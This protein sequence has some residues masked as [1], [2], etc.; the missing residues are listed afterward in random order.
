[1][2]PP[3][4]RRASRSLPQLVIVSGPGLRVWVADSGRGETG[5]YFVHLWHCL[6]C[7][8]A[9]CPPTDHLPPLSRPLSPSP[10]PAMPLACFSAAT[11]GIYDFWSTL[12]QRS[13]A[14][15]CVCDCVCVCV[16]VSV[17]WA[18][19]LAARRDYHLLRPHTGNVIGIA[20]RVIR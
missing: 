9:T 2:C 18:A 5:A 3:A 20:R 8:A 13:S 14:S 12:P 7:C 17:N 4:L 11:D 19:L 16:C 15:E 6:H 1:M 10:P